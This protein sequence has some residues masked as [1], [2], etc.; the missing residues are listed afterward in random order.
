MSKYKKIELQ[1]VKTI[2]IKK[3]KSK[4]ELNNFAKIFNPQKEKFLEFTNS[5][6]NI[7]ASENL[8]IVVNKIIESRKKNKPVIL[9]M[10]AH[11]IKVGL[12]PIIID[13]IE[14]KVITAIAMNSASAIHDVETALFG[15]TSEDVAENI[16]DGTFGMS[17]ETGEFINNC[18]V[19]FQNNSDF[20]YGE[21]LGA[22]LISQK[23]KNKKFSL[24]ATC[25][26]KNIPI[27]V[28]AAI[29]T[30]II[31][32]QPTM[33]GAATGEMSFRDF[34]IFA[35]VV[36]D[37]KNGGVVL[38]FGSSVIMPEVFLKAL[39]VARNLGFKANGFTTANFDMLRHYRPTMNVVLRPT[40]SGGKGF[41]FSGHHEIMMPLLA[42]M[43]KSSFK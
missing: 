41:D 35:N 20:G 18:L 10:G 11:V 12:S 6:P 28:H 24:L 19:K 25:Y 31:H 29:G 15:Q 22:E 2:S 43:I 37:L 26:Q 3:R 5:L 4:V 42:A 27:T 39:T 30:D 17:K 21:A 1:N 7:L 34:K 36:K 40:Q 14:R 23:A 8:K 32:Q 13:L 16:L 9:M 38:N 33:D